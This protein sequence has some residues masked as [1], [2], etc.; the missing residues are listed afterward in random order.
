MKEVKIYDIFPKQVNKYRDD[1][2]P[3]FSGV[4]FISCKD[5]ET[6]VKD[7]DVVITCT[8][9]LE[10][11]KRFVRSSWLKDDVL[12]IAVNYDSSF[13]KDIMTGGIF[14]CDDKNQYLQT[15]KWSSYFHGGYSTEEQI[16]AD[17]GEIAAGKL[18]PVTKGK[19]EAVLM[20]I[21]SHDI[22]TGQLLYANALEKGVGTWVK[23]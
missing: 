4:T 20:G 17:M 19:G 15:Q 18:P 10:K 23:K 1:L 9:I 22:M 3:E 11:P 12:A 2:S 13:D 8:P 16:Y 5:V 21:A 7:A 6:T 14:V